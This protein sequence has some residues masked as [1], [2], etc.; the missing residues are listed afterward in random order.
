M[1]KFDQKSY[2]R[3]IDLR[4][5]IEADPILSALE[6][7]VIPVEVDGKTKKTA[8]FTT[9]TTEA[10]IAVRKAGFTAVPAKQPQKVEAP[11]PKTIAEK[12]MLASLTVKGWSGRKTDNEAAAFTAMHYQANAEW[13]RFSKALVNKGV[14]K[15]I[16]K[17]EAAARAT[18]KELTLPWNENGQR[19]LPAAAFHDYQSKM[20]AH[21][22][23]HEAAVDKLLNDYSD[24]KE[25]ARSELGG[26]FND[27][28][29]P[30]SEELLAKYEF[31]TELTALDVTGDFRVKMSDEE[32]QR[33]QADIQS[34][35]E[36]RLSAAM[37]D[38]YSRLHDVVSHMA[39]R[40]KAYN[41]AADGK[42]AD[43]ND[44]K[45]VENPFRE[46]TL[47]NVRDIVDLMP[48]LNLTNDPALN[49]LAASV[50]KTLLEADAKTLRTDDD[51]RAEVA[52]Q[53]DAIVNAMS[54][55]M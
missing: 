19:I 28:D 15:A 2:S 22:D 42:D 34:R 13:T 47:N 27:D 12:A 3:A 55:M 44:I 53:A 21:R 43:G 5:R 25:E 17:A 33:L 29:Y 26:L 18:H 30:S 14:L 10:A 7:E 8:R 32:M 41:P 54:G 35:T 9:H 51:K 45:R 16:K 48:K 46:S 38:V 37:T 11:K 40:L 31:A 49:E 1:T 4:S 36:Q 24:L 50:R 20:G 23:E 39:E 6:F 52:A